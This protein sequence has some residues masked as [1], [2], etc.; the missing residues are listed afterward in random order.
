M[1]DTDYRWTEFP[2]RFCNF[3]AA[4]DGEG[5]LTRTWFHARRSAPPPGVRDDSALADVRTQVEEF[6]EGKRRDFDLELVIEG[7]SEFERAVWR[8]MQDIPFGETITY[9]DIARELGGAPDAARAVGAACNSNPICLIV[10][11]HRVVGAGGALVGFGGGLPLK[12]ALLD[13]ESVVAGR[14]RDLFAA[15]KR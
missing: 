3:G 8:R 7:G 13:F 2:T 5:R 11:C 10:P 15:A 6:C 12:R 9:G 14:P 4:I 1:T